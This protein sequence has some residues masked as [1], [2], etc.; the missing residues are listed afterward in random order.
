M[1]HCMIRFG[2]LNAA[3]GVGRVRG[4]RDRRCWCVVCGRLRMHQFVQERRQRRALNGKHAEKA[5]DDAESAPGRHGPQPKLQLRP[6]P[7]AA[8]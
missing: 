4:V 2:G 8:R 5:D 3:D 6:A 7:P 1:K